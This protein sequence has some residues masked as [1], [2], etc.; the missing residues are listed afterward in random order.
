MCRIF[1]SHF[2][3]S[4]LFITF[5]TTIFNVH[6]LHWPVSLL[7][8]E[9][10]RNFWFAC[11]VMHCDYKS[12]SCKAGKGTGDQ[13]QYILPSFE[14]QS[15]VQKLFYIQFTI[16]QT[17]HNNSSY[18][19]FH[20]MCFTGNQKANPQEELYSFLVLCFNTFVELFW[21][22]ENHQV[23]LILSKLENKLHHFSRL[24]V[25]V[26]ACIWKVASRVWL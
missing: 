25:F 16:N 23:W 10:L 12:R 24:L 3:V 1:I 7:W 19:D 8:F 11:R 13:M 22:K 18:M 14:F 9:K 17:N 2:I 6:V 20:A 26:S 5:I 21:S 4:P 15:Y